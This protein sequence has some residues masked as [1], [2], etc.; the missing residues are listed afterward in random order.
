MF[1]AESDSDLTTQL[2]IPF[3]SFLLCS[4]K[5]NSFLF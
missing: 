3:K 1:E 5:N 2:I 4:K